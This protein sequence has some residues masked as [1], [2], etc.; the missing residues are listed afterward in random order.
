VVVCASA[1]DNSELKVEIDVDRIL[2]VSGWDGKRWRE[3]Y[4]IYLL[5]ILRIYNKADRVPQ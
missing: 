5:C 1:Q 4:Y 3:T 2:A